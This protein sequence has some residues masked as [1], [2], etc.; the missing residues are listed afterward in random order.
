MFSTSTPFHQGGTKPPEQCSNQI[1]DGQTS[2]GCADGPQSSA[3]GRPS[4]P[5]TSPSLSAP[6]PVPRLCSSCE[7]HVT[8]GW[9]H[10]SAEL[11]CDECYDDAG[12]DDEN[13]YYYYQELVRLA[14]DEWSRWEST[15]M[16]FRGARGVR[17]SCPG[18]MT[19]LLPCV[20]DAH[21]EKRATRPRA[22]LA[23]LAV[24]ALG[25]PRAAEAALTRAASRC[26]G[27]YAATSA[28]AA[29]RRC[30][31]LLG[32]VCGSIIHRVTSPYGRQPTPPFPSPFPPY[33]QRPVSSAQPGLQDEVEREVGFAGVTDACR[34]F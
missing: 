12:S 3:A 30:N 19:P 6:V 1:D 10:E 8:S 18:F 33:T 16:G 21:G 7:R 4:M 22:M 32:M 9:A 11:T 27:S 2:T 28:K 24:S 17:T 34:V 25:C 15:E 20:G 14:P 29:A 31:V 26:A 5:E 13:P 23:R